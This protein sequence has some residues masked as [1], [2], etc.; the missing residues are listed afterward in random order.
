MLIKVRLI[1][2]LLRISETELPRERGVGAYEVVKFQSAE[3]MS[4]RIT[5]QRK[6]A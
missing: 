5:R 1:P 4:L 3:N 6:E 2:M